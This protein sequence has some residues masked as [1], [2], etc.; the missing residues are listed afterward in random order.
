MTRAPSRFGR[1]AFLA[2]LV[3]AGFGAATIAG[4]ILAPN[5]ESLPPQMAQAQLLDARDPYIISN[6]AE[7]VLPAVVTVSTK[8]FVSVPEM[9][10]IQQFFDP[11]FQ[12]SEPG[13]KREQRGLGSGVIVD[14]KRG[15]I[16]TNN[17]VVA[18][19]DEITVSLVDGTNLSAEVA[20][21]DSYSDVAVLR[22]TGDHPPLAEIPLG[23]SDALRLGEIVLA[24]GS[25][26]GFRGSVTMGIVSAKGRANGPAGILYGD[27]IQT[28]AAINQGNS[29]GALVNMSGQL[30]G[31]NSWIASPGMGGNAGLGFAIPTN[32]AKPIM[33]SL[34]EDGRVARGWLGISMQPLDETLAESLGATGSQ[35]IVVA[36][37]GANTPA[38][39]G[40]LQ[41]GDVIEQLDGVKI[42]S[43]GRMRTE[44]ARRPAGKKV[45]VDVLRDGRA[46]ALTVTLG[47]QPADLFARSRFGGEE[48]PKSD[49]LRDGGV[50]DGL[51][52][53]GLDELDDRAISK[54]SIDDK[55]KRGAVATAV[56][57]GSAADKAGLREGDVIIE[58]NRKPVTGGADFR[59]K[60]EAAGNQVML[61]VRRGGSVLFLVV[62]R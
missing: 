36:D 33:D 24:V 14:A 62:S 31:I 25:P 54:Y 38:E 58:L 49:D 30:V 32:L 34:L 7:G 55:V 13:A 1:P 18:G 46:K 60:Y 45:K 16:M 43:L 52:V 50:L 12:H 42:D 56:E 19:A 59:T 26:L 8:T 48:T 5:Q 11:F 6:V 53:Q 51:R 29:G 37:V 17:H 61:R 27:F 15:I 40:G 10:G 44:V 35:G 2:L 47:E 20:G 39:K 22:I 3:A 57:P 23:D 21:T 4:G 28:D 9:P 41:P